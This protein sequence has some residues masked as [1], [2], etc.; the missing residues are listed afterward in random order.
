MKCARCGRSLKRPSASGYGPRCQLAV[1]GS[2]PKRDRAA[3]RE[4]KSTPDMF[5][6]LA[7]MLP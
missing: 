4:D 2:M 6:V 3:H 1:L 5:E 7:R